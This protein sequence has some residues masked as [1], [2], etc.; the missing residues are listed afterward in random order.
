[1]ECKEVWSDIRQNNSSNNNNN[2]KDKTK[3]LGG[4]VAKGRWL[5]LPSITIDNPVVNCKYFSD[6]FQQNP[7]DEAAFCQIVLLGH[8][9]TRLPPKGHFYSI[10]TNSLFFLFCWN[11]F[12][13]FYSRLFFHY[14]IR[15]FCL[16]SYCKLPYLLVVL[17]LCK[18]VLE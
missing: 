12:V 6:Y 18:D 10:F 15:P 9:F 3:V 7:P 2:Y 17:I 11:L 4:L 16:V 13:S 5:L 1:M 8:L 14:I